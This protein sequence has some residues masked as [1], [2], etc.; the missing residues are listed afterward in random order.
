MPGFRVLTRSLAAATLLAALPLAGQSPCDPNPSTP[1][2]FILLDTSGSL[3]WTAKCTQA[4]FDAGQCS[5][6]CPTGECFAPLQ[7]DD[8]GSKFYQMKEALQ[9]AVAGESG[10]QFGFASF[11]QDALSVRAKHWI[12]EAGSDG[13]TIPGWGPY[14]A[15][16]AR[17][18]FGLTWT[19]DTG[20]N[21]NEIGCYS[22]KPADLVDPWELA[23]V[24]R[25]PK[26]GLAFNQAVLFYVRQSGTFY[27]VTY[28][29]TGAPSPGASTLQVVVRIDRCGSSACTSLFPVG[30]TTTTWNR[31]AE[32]LSW[33]NAST[34]NT[35]RFNPQPTYFTSLAVDATASNAC[36]GWDPNTD[37]VA[38]KLNNY[39]LRF[40]TIS[41]DPRG[42]FFYPGDVLPWDWTADHNSDIQ[43]RMA[44]NL[45]A[46][47]AATPDF[48]TSPYLQ[49]ARI[50]ADSFLRLRDER[51]RPLIVAGTTPLG[52]S[53][54][55]FRTWYA[56]CATGTCPTGAG[57]Q[58]IAAVNDPLWV[59]RRKVLIV[60][61]DGDGTCAD[62]PCTTVANLYNQN[63]ISVYAVGFGALL[64]P[65]SQLDCIA[66]AGGTV[67]PL[68][69][70]TKQELVDALNSIFAAAK[71]P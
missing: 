38:D 62:D 49:D 36:S 56:G 10:I 55:S 22:T 17:E 51:Q 3:N 39:N 43:V 58:G 61:T 25:L 35:D 64:S 7:G 16:G 23:R 47:P 63:G 11:N 2:V 30:Q 44:P 34:T 46:N 70:D 57:W 69:A 24:Q 5:P 8:P 27:K 53:V 26:A 68:L 20:N 65:G 29:P 31:S 6:L 50:G 28:T 14:P 19:C 66:S 60:L 12:Y 18:V 67:S 32:F 41:S 13:P 40:P 21:D 33:D 1:Y 37:T 45:A 42:S 54:K 15:V 71:A 4:Q 59:C 52:N 9:T 48:R